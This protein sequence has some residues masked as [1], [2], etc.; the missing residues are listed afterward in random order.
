MIMAL[1]VDFAI[2]GLS[3]EFNGLTGITQLDLSVLM[4]NEKTSWIQTRYTVS[5][6]LCKSFKDCL[7]RERECK[8]SM[9]LVK[10]LRELTITLPFMDIATKDRNRTPAE[11][12][13]NTLKVL[14][15][16]AWSYLDLER[17]LITRSTGRSDI[18]Y[19]SN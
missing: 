16:H 7:C 3:K 12:I 14:K 15:R 1:S 5:Y 10:V 4:V 19:Y 11:A 8:L 18:I 6:K 13:S 17:H 9:E 2:K